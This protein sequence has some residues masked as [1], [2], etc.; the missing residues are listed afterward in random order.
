VSLRS[1]VLVFVV[2]L[3]SWLGATAAV[4]YSTQRAT[5]ERRILV[6]VVCQSVLIREEH[7]DPL[8]SV[9]R[10][11]FNAVLVELG[12]RCPPSKGDMP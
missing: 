1:L 5:Q 3:L 12:E 11:R 2:S 7:G 10:A 8:A 6:D 4:V 9:Y